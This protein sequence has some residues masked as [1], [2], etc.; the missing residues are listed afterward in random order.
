MRR[1]DDENIASCATR[2]HVDDMRCPAMEK[3]LRMLGINEEVANMV[4][5]A[6][7][8]RGDICLACGGLRSGVRETR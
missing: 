5:I 7:A 6:L 2:Q 8:R 1:Q 4:R 3:H